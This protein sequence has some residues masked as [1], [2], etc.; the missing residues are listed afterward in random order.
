MFTSDL[1]HV[2]KCQ[3]LE[4]ACLLHMFHKCKP[5]LLQDHLAATYV[6]HPYLPDAFIFTEVFADI[7]TKP[8][9]RELD[10]FPFTD[11]YLVID[12]HLAMIASYDV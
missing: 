9:R 1:S 6:M 8:E 3:F 11:Q 12:S 7:L 5:K 10:R 2:T 4:P